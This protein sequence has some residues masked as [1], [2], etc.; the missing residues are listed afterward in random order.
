[1]RASRIEN[2]AILRFMEISFDVEMRFSNR[3]QGMKEPEAASFGF[4]SGAV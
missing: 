2:N 1:V 4:T 3:P